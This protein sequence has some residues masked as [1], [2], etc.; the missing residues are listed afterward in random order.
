MQLFVGRSDSRDWA[1]RWC[2]KADPGTFSVWWAHSW[3]HCGSRWTP[4][5]CTPPVCTGRTSCRS[6]LGA[7]ESKAKDSLL[8]ILLQLPA[9]W[10]MTSLH[11]AQSGCVGVTQTSTHQ[12]LLVPLL[13][14]AVKAKARPPSGGN[15]WAIIQTLLESLALA[16]FAGLH[17]VSNKVFIILTFSP[18]LLAKPCSRTKS[19]CRI[20]HLQLHLPGLFWL[21][22]L[23]LLTPFNWC[24]G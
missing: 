21:V 10:C 1:W 2:C 3:T 7:R 22:F 15:L 6:G 20:L 17:I 11:D 9:S 18:H 24:L 4:Y 19:H 14:S 5:K 8:S 16:V 12:R 23:I 13:V